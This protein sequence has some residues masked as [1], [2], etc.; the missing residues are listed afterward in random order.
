MFFVNF[1]DFRKLS[2]APPSCF[3]SLQPRHTKSEKLAGIPPAPQA[4]FRPRRR[5]RSTGPSPSAHCVRF[6]LVRF[7]PA[8]RD[9]EKDR[10]LPVLLLRLELA[11]IEPASEISSTRLSS[12]IV[13]E[14][15]FPLPKSPM[16]DFQAR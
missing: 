7:P 8:L 6:L 15:L 1:Y 10:F 12:T 4:P 13:I 5:R 16:T 9:E 11:G 3:D 14:I 2:L